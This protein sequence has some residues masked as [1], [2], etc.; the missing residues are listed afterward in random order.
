[1]AVEI[2]SIG[3]KRS[4]LKIEAVDENLY[5]AKA[6]PNGDGLWKKLH[7]LLRPR[8]G[9]DVIILGLAAHNEI[10][11]ASSHPVSAKAR[12]PEGFYNFDRLVTHVHR[13]RS[14][15]V[16]YRNRHPPVIFLIQVD[17]RNRIQ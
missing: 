17:F 13:C 6:R 2:T 12:L 4:H 1:P 10:A 3:T 11:H 16:F 9:C 8:I 7:D 14:D 5:H 15:S